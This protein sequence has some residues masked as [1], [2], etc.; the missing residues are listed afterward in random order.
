MWAGLLPDTGL[1]W[2][3]G[4]EFSKHEGEIAFQALCS[5]F[6]PW[7]VISNT[8]VEDHPLKHVLVSSRYTKK[9]S[10]RWKILGHNIYNVYGNYVNGSKILRMECYEQS[11]IT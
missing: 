3:L 4:Y 10:V 2:V 9:P 6:W 5:G 8:E 7:I 1:Q 11:Q